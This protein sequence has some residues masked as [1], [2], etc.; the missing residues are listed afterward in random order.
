MYKKRGDIMLQ[1]IANYWLTFLLSIISTGLVLV[2]KKIWSLYQNEKKQKFS[3][4]HNDIVLELKTAIKESMMQS[5]KDDVF[6]QDQIDSLK[7]GILSIQGHN[8]KEY[9][10][11]LLEEE[12]EITLK[13]LEVCQE[14]HD[15]Y[16]YLGGN[17]T[18]DLLFDL[19]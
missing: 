2:C 11:E 12:K 6:L 1:T 10:R 16:N 19:V 18:G 7:R 15:V 17:H 9:C 3:Q 8:F 5:E 14:E 4:E 13:E